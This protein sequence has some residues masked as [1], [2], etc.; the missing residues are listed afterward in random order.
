MDLVVPDPDF[1]YFR[2]FGFGLC[3][4]LAVAVWFLTFLVASRVLDAISIGG[5]E[6]CNSEFCS[7]SSLELSS[8]S[9]GSHGDCIRVLCW[10]ELL[11]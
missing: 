5:M 6:V 1:S 8:R 2:F 7:S 11:F 9:G 3:L 10:D 4:L